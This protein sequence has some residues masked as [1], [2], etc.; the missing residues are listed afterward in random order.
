ML[1]PPPGATIRTVGPA[2][3]SRPS[4][5]YRSTTRPRITDETRNDPAPDLSR[6]PGPCLTPRNARPALRPRDGYVTPK[7]ATNLTRR[8]R[9]RLRLQQLAPPGRHERHGLA[10]SRRPTYG[11]THADW[12]DDGWD[13]ILTCSYGRQWNRLWRNN[14]DGTFTDVAPQ[15]TF[16]GDDHLSVTAVTR[17]CNDTAAR[18]GL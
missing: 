11:C 3:T 16:D 10:T 6:R 14:G 13:D 5:G 2:R 18:T 17:R 7:S 15:T 9:S 4:A 12:N 1:I 8:Q